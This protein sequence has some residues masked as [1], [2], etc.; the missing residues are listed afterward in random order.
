MTSNPLPSTRLCGIYKT[1]QKFLTKDT[2]M[3]FLFLLFFFCDINNFIL[4]IIKKM[5]SLVTS[6]TD[7]LLSFPFEN[8]IENKKTTI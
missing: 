1:C 8:H 4:K 7:R 5:S 2:T 3:R 6:I